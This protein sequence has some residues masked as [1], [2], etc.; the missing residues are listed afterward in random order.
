MIRGLAEMTDTV[1]CT[2]VPVF[3]RPVRRNPELIDDRLYDSVSREKHYEKAGG[4]PDKASVEQREQRAAEIFSITTEGFDDSGVVLETDLRY[5]TGIASSTVSV[6]H[7]RSASA[8]VFTPRGGSRWRKL[9]TGDVTHNLVR[10]SDI[11]ILIVP[12]H[13]ESAV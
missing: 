3:P 5:R 13:D 11:P 6:A 2:D 8:I 7:D 12:E 9:V 4:T 10:S 1:G